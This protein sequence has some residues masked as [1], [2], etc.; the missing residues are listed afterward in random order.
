MKLIEINNKFYKE[1]KV[2]ILSSNNYDAKIG[3]IFKYI[4][5]FPLHTD[6]EIMKTLAKNDGLTLAELL[7]WFKYPKP[8]EGQI[9]CWN[10]KVNY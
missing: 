8:F 3:S 10:D 2:V 9:I 1:A 5:K 7:Q 6:S 4:K